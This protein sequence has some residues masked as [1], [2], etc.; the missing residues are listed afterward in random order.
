MLTRESIA[1]VER[2][3][4]AHHERIHSTFAVRQQGPKAWQDW[5][6]ATTAWHVHEHP[7]DFLWG[8]D[9]LARLR[10]SDRQAMDDAILYLEVDP[11]YFRSGY[12]KERLIRGLKAAKLTKQDRRRLWNVIWNVAAGRN[13]REFRN[14]CSLAAMLGDSD[15]IQ[16]LEEISPERDLSSAR[17]FSYLLNFLRRHMAPRRT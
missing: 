12:L 7:T 13:R 8:D 11:W 16:Q 9:F 4:N 3:V 17:K 6:D 14:Y 15:V 2:T 10:S 5:E 1:S